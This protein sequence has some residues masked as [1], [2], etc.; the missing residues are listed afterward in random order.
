MKQLLKKRWHRVPVALISAF[1]MVGLLA[2]GVFADVLIQE[3]QDITQGIVLQYDYGTITADAIELPN[4]KVGESFTETYPGAVTVVLGPD[5]V[6]K[7]FGISTTASGLYTLL[8]VIITLTDRPAGSTVEFYGYGGTAGGYVGIGL[9][10]PGTYLF[11]QTISGVAGSSA[12]SAS[13]TV[14]FT[15]EDTWFP[16]EH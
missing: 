6:G 8:D 16:P 9:D 10:V 13:S 1:L 15:L 7:E 5:G 12:G 4:V 14:T 2:G 11:D 3:D